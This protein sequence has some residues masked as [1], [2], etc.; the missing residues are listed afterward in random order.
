MPLPRTPLQFHPL[1]LAAACLLLQSA[2]RADPQSVRSTES[3]AL[4][5]STCHWIETDDPAP[6]RDAGIP[7]LHGR[8][9]KELLH[10][11]REYR[12]NIGN[13]TLMNRI[14]KGYSDEELAR[15]AD[16][17]AAVGGGLKEE[18]R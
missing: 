6:D 15:I 17:I 1:L 18:S 16:Y 5:C 13:P 11:L 8:S 10:K 12:S 4:T 2:V 14:A 7:A 9:A 3:L